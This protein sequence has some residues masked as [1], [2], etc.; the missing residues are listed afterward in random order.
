MLNKVENNSKSGLKINQ[1][2]A[3]AL[4]LM[5]LSSKLPLFIPTNEKMQTVGD[6]HQEVLPIENN[7]QEEVKIAD[8][9]EREMNTTSRSLGKRKEQTEEV[10]YRSIDEITISK[11]MDLTIRCGISK[12]DFKTVM[13]N[14]KTDTSGF[15]E[16]N[17]DTIYDLCEKY[18]LNEIFFCGLIAAE[19]GWNIEKNHRNKCNYISMMKNG[20]MIGF[21]SP[22]K[23][24][25]AAA[26]LLHNKYL[27]PGGAYYKG[28]TLASMQ[29]IFCPNSSTW[30][31]L[32][33][34]C[35][36]QIVK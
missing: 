30:V 10:T 11:N 7:I 26:K 4:M 22:E 17:S 32:V 2:I 36:K 20:K 1:I 31:G 33:Y 3:I 16:K 14:L 24:L 8:Q 5:V 15:F 27:T 35:M 19:S 28:K 34:G 6:N 18:E 13:T 9:Y 29:K 12:E 21:S 23:G 25:E